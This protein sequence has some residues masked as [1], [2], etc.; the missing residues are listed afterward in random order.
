MWT[1]HY[2]ELFF[3]AK[4]S[5]PWNALPNNIQ[6]TKE[7]AFLN[8]PEMLSYIHNL[9]D[10]ARSFFH[11]AALGAIWTLIWLWNNRKRNISSSG[12][13]GET[14]PKIPRLWM[15]VLTLIFHCITV[16]IREQ[17]SALKNV[18]CFYFFFCKALEFICAKQ[19]GRIFCSWWG[20]CQNKKTKQKEKKSVSNASG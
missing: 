4:F 8:T 1:N 12:G 19:N 13:S 6:A 14:Q 2:R 5:R 7:A 3:L 20:L 10:W 18:L 16:A 17:K 15:C 11:L 9:I